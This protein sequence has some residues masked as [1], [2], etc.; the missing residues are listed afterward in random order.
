VRHLL[1]AAAS[2]PGGG[3]PLFLFT[4]LTGL[5]SGNPLTHVWTNGLGEPA[6]LTD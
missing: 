2:L 6:R 4:D 5:L 1:S 3:S